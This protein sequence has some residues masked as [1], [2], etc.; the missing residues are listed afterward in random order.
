MIFL[1]KS[2]YLRFLFL[3]VHLLISGGIIN[4]AFAQKEAPVLLSDKV[5]ININLFRANENAYKYKIEGFD[6]LIKQQDTSLTNGKLLRDWNKSKK[7]FY[8]FDYLE[9]YQFLEKTIENAKSNYSE[10]ALLLAELNLDMGIILLNLEQYGESLERLLFAKEIFEKEGSQDQKALIYAN[11]GDF[12]RR[13]YYN[14]KAQ[15]FLRTG[16]E[17]S[18]VSPNV[19]AK[20]Y[21]RMAST[22]TEASDLDSSFFYSNK[23]L[24]ISNKLNDPDLIAISENEIGFIYRNKKQVDK[25]FPHYYKADSLWRSVGFVAKALRANINII[26]AL[27]DQ[28]RLDEA[29]KLCEKCIK[30]CEGKNW[31]LMELELYELIS[32]LYNKKG[33]KNK[34][35]YYLIKKLKLHIDVLNQRNKMQ[36]AFVEA[37]YNQKKN[38]EIIKQQEQKIEIEK[39]EVLFL[40]KQKTYFIII[41]ISILLIAILLLVILALQRKK[42]KLIIKEKQQQEEYT[43]IIQASLEEKNALLQEVNHRVKNNLQ[44]ISSMVYLQNAS[45]D[46]AIA[47]TALEDI[48]RRIDAMGLVHEMLYT[49]DDVGKIKVREYINKLIDIHLP[50]HF[51]EINKIKI[52]H[53]IMDE[54]F[55][56]SICIALGMITSEAISNAVKHAFNNVEYPEIEVALMPKDDGY[57]YT[58]QDNGVGISNEKLSLK[59]KTFGLKLMEIFAQKIKGKLEVKKNNVGTIISITF[60]K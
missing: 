56:I 58:I 8:E 10:N 51:K 44:S 12:Y 35:N 42:N 41:A 11:V 46:D 31:L 53:R 15:E 20:L 18:N 54:Y 32:K 13:T 7:E 47:K 29:I 19:K 33:N 40:K 9:A 48:Q 39:A 3:S 21:H 14:T 50:I 36:V 23:A 52:T 57:L 55:S 26:W 60:K 17:L 37:Y 45:I 6:A 16:L 24:E 5:P 59:G 4:K 34:S 25:S 27:K 43:K 22:K 38:E 30:E 2:S 28:N 1:P 49:S